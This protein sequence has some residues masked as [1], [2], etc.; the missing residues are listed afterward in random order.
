MFVLLGRIMDVRHDQL[1]GNK[2]C[3]TFY[4][5]WGLKRLQVALYFTFG[6]YPHLLGI[7]T[8]TEPSKQSKTSAYLAVSSHYTH[9]CIHTSIHSQPYSNKVTPEPYL[10]KRC[11]ASRSASLIL[12]LL[13]F[14]T[15]FVEVIESSN[16]SLLM[17]LL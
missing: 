13:L 8:C 9:T 1:C 11:T 6:S 12:V 14:N 15:F 7:L 10:C 5:G 3:N 17:S 16:F 4:C 2:N